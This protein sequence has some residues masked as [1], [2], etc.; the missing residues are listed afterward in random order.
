MGH[1]TS[2]PD[3]SDSFLGTGYRISGGLEMRTLSDWA[4]SALQGNSPLFKE[5]LWEPFL[6]FYLR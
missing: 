4:A 3:D 5:E 6:L 2:Y 1:L